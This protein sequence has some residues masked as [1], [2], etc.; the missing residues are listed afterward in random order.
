LFI[1]YFSTEPGRCPRDNIVC[2][3][4]VCS[5]DS[6]CPES[7]KCCSNG[8]RCANPISHDGH[9]D[10]LLDEVSEDIAYDSSKY[11]IW[12]YMVDIFQ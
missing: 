12:L 5:N 4:S 10:Y 2:I 6:D 9:D 11:I 7:K 8:C 3:R 1:F